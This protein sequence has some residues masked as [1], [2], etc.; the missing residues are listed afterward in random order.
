MESE[1]RKKRMQQYFEEI[2]DKRSPWKIKHK[3]TEIIVMTICAVTGGCD[4]WEVIEDF[5]KVKETWFREQMNL[6]LA[7]GIPSHDTFER[8]FGMIEPTE[9][10]KNFIKWVREISQK[11]DGEVVSIDGKTLCGS[12]SGTRSAIHM[13]SAWANN[14]QMVLGQLATEEKSN[15]ITAVPELLNLLDVKGCT[16]TADAMSCQKEI[17]AKITEKQADYAIALKENQP[18]LRKDAEDYFLA[19]LSDKNQ[20]LFSKPKI[21]RTLEKGHGRIETRQY[22]LTTDISWLSQL[23]EWK[24]LNSLGMVKSK[25]ECNGVISEDV[26]YYISSLT[27]VSLFAKAVRAHWGIEN[28]LHWCLDVVFDEDHIRMRKDHSAENMAVVRHIVL[29]I[30]KNFPTPKKMSLS[31]KRQKC[32]YDFDFLK[33]V[34]LFAADFHA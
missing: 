27:D 33:S 28:S 32:E 8:V 26:R 31:R 24:N 13:V 18:N 5:C 4:S 15:E 3:M 34:L 23:K 21:T 17:V 20:L 16:V 25:T 22:Y 9:F 12:K 29:N 6:T 1:V 7:N 10:E 19:A 30:L 2:T 11:T 14:N